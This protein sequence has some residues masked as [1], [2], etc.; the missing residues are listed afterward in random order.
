MQQVAKRRPTRQGSRIESLDV[1]RGVAV[2]GILLMNVVNFG[3]GV[4][5]YFNLDAGGSDTWLDRSVGVA[6]ELLPDQKFMAMFS[7]L[8]G[9]GIVLFHERAVATGKHA[10]RLSLWRNLLL[11]G[12]GL[13]HSIFW[14]GDVLVVYAVCAPVVIAARRLP[15]AALLALAVGVIALSPLL[16]VVGQDSVGPNGAGLGEY[17]GITGDM[18]DEV[19]LW[20]LA[21]F[22]V[23][24]LGLML[25][26]IVA[27]RRG[28]VTG[29]LEQSVYRRWLVIG[30]CAGLL[31]A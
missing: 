15:D 12:I 11:F 16:A 26:G 20:L 2:L 13:V 7:L 9:A 24:A 23:R 28:S 27:Y 22:L 3:L 1:I 21:D 17:W 31:A 8:F 29:A 10:V 25:L 4:P 6:G 19:S 18:N 30:C 5:A 14:D